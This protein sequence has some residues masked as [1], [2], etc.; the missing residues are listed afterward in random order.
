MQLKHKIIMNK[1]P[2]AIVNIYIFYRDMH[3]KESHKRPIVLIN[4]AIP[5][6]GTF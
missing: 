3:A 6:C 5:I 2:F 4:G 1:I